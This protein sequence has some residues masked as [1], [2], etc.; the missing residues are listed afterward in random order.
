M[1]PFASDDDDWEGTGKGKGKGKGKDERAVGG[2]SNNPRGKVYD[3]HRSNEAIGW[4]P[5][6]PSFEEFMTLSSSSS[7]STSSLNAAAA[8]AN[9]EA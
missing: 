8:A 2:R 9:V 5:T 6:Y 7:P 4:T 1:P 3:G